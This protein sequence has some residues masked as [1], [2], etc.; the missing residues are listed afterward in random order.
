M[1]LQTLFD[2]WC[3]TTD[4]VQVVD[5]GTLELRITA[6]KPGIDGKLVRLVIVIVLVLSKA[7]LQILSDFHS[8]FAHSRSPDLNFAAPATSSTSERVP[9]PAPP[10]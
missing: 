5:M 3:F 10:S 1:Q 9:T 6:A 7:R 4:Y 8:H 2:F